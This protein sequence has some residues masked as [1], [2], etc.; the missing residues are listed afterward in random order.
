MFEDQPK[1]TKAT[2]KFLRRFLPIKPRTCYQA[3][4]E[5]MSFRDLH[6][7]PCN[8][9]VTFWS[10]RNSFRFKSRRHSAKQT[11]QKQMPATTRCW[12]RNWRNWSAS[13]NISMNCIIVNLHPVHGDMLSNVVNL[14][15]SCYHRQCWSFCWFVSQTLHLQLQ[16]H[17][18]KKF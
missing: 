8:F 2:Y 6:S 12:I 10:Q 16:V 7:P 11:S 9:S 5:G 13:A 14:T 4:W 18:L 3:L 17:W 15:L 1:T